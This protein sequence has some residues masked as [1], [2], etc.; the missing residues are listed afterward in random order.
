MIITRIIGGLGNQLF[1]YAAARSLSLFHQVAFKLD[2]T[3]FDEYKLR[4]FELSFFHC[5]LDYATPDEIQSYTSEH[6]L[7]KVVRRMR[8]PHEN[9]MYKEPHFHYDP[10]FFKAKP[11]LYLRGYWQSEKYFKQF[12]PAIREDFTFKQAPIQKV[13]QVALRLK[14]EN[15]VAVHIR[16]GDYTRRDIFE[17]HGVMEADYYTRAL[18]IMSQKVNAPKIYFFTDDAEWV[19]HNLDLPFEYEFVS[20]AITNTAIEDF[21]LMSCCRNNI[22]ANSSFSW[23]AAWLNTW[24][25]KIIIAPTNWFRDKS[26]STKDV[27]PAGWIRI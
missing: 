5:Q 7:Q 20:G 23:W 27:I 19:K 25:D 14:E 12:E 6:L 22:I 9:R 21:Y 17:V 16:R 13:A 3:A 4:Q 10:G 26:H 8:K 15:S 24:Q 11:D 1:Q 2:V 18:D